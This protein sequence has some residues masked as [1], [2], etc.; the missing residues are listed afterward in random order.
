MRF[1][2]ITFGLTSLVLLAASQPAVAGSP[3]PTR[4]AALE[5]ENAALSERLAR[6]EEA[7]AG[8]AELLRHVRVEQEEIEGLRGPHVII[9]GANLHVRSGSGF[10]DDCGQTRLGCTHPDGL[11]GRGNLIV[12]Y[13]EILGP[14]RGG[15]HNLVVG[16]K[17]SYSSYG[18]FV[19]GRLNAL[20]APETSVL[21]GFRNTASGVH[22]SISG[23]SGNRARGNGA[24]VSGGSDN[25]AEGN[26]SSV[27]GGTSNQAL[28][29]ASAICGGI[30]NQ[31]A[32]DFSSVAGGGE[33]EASGLISSVGGGLERI[34][35]E[36]GSWAAGSLFE[37]D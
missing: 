15:S 22:S 12:G 23:G 17:H 26:I 24:A 30:Y 9:E 28:G 32:G 2:I 33:N 19:A 10:T 21:G 36:H 35:D 16:A 27:G 13:N 37:S 34:A 20:L 29:H 5:A 25:V 14:V 7:S 11:L 6:L 31:A 1:S 8:V 3:L 18:G 4:L